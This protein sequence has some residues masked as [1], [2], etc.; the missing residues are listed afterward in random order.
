[1]MRCIRRCCEETGRPCRRC[2]LQSNTVR[3]PL[4]GDRCCEGSV[5]AGA[6]PRCGSGASPAPPELQ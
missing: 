4:Q 2:L 6:R 5:T 3:E 1:M